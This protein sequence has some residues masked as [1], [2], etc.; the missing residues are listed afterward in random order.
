MDLNDEIGQ[1]AP[2]TPI[3]LGIKTLLQTNKSRVQPLDMR[4]LCI[5]VHLDMC[6]CSCV[7]VFGVWASLLLSS[8]YHYQ[9]VKEVVDLICECLTRVQDNPQLEKFRRINLVRACV[10]V[11]VCVCVCPTP[12]PF[13]H[14]TRLSF[15]RRQ[16]L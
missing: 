15:G 4:L 11:C 6:L 14:T 13:N 3:S 8:Q 12:H 16:V 7:C 2:H 5:I 9:V 1:M 10:C